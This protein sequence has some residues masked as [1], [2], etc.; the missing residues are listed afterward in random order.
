MNRPTLL[1]NLVVLWAALSLTTWGCGDDIQIPDATVRD[2]GDTGRDV[3]APDTP[4]D[5]TVDIPADWP[6]DVPYDLADMEEPV[7]LAPRVENAFSRDGSDIV[8][9]FSEAMDPTTT[10]VAANYRVEGSDATSI[11]VLSVTLEERFAFLTLDLTSTTINPDLT[12]E[13]IVSNAQDLTGNVI[14]SRYNRVTVHRSL[15][16]AIVWHQHQPL[17]LD[18]NRDEMIGPWVRKHATKDYWD[19]TAILDGYEDIHLTVNLT[20]VL[21]IQ[22]A[23]YVERLAPYVDP[24]NNTVDEEAYF[25]EMAGHTDPFVDLT[26]RDTPTRATATEEEL[27]LFYAGPWA[28]VSTSDAIMQRFPEYVA[29]RDGDRTSYDQLE[30]AYLKVWFEVAWFDPDF[31]HGPVQLSNGWVVDLSDVVDYH[32]ENGTFTLNT[33]YT[34][35]ASSDAER[36]A[37]LEVLANRL[38]AENYKIMADVIPLHRSMIYDPIT[39]EGQIEVITTPF[40]HPILPLLYDSDLARFGQPTD[41]LPSPAFAFPD[42]AYAQVAMARRYYE[43]VF[44]QP[45]RGMWP[46]EGSVAEEIVGMLALNGIEWIAT[47]QE[48]LNRSTSGSQPHYYPFK[49]DGDTAT[50]NAGSDDDA[51]VIV[52]RDS[53]LS[54]AI[55]FAYQTWRGE[56]AAADFLRNLLTMAPRFGQPDRLL[57]VV[58]D[59]ENA[60]ELYRYEH[61]GKG[62]HHALYRMLLESQEVGELVT[63]TPAEYLHG[64][65]DRSVAS[66]PIADQRELEPLWRGSWIGATFATWIG[67]S[68]ENLGWNYLLQART[69]LDLAPWRDAGGVTNHGVPRPNPLEGPPEP[70]GTPS[71]TVPSYEEQLAAYLAWQEIYAAEGSDWFWWYGEDQT[72][73]SNDDTP[74]DRGFRSHLTGMY[75]YIREWQTERFYRIF[76]DC[77]GWDANGDGTFAVAE[78]PAGCTEDPPDLLVPPDFAPIIQPRADYLRGPFET[79]PVCNGIFQPNETEWSSVAG[80]FYD[81][82]SSGTAA[83]RNDD[84][85]LIYYGYDRI[86][87]SPAEEAV[88]LAI[89]F[90]EDIAAKR[91]S[92]YRVSIYTN[93]KHILDPTMGTYQPDPQVLNSTSPED[94]PLLFV[95]G[96]AG[97]QIE[98][99]FS[100]ASQIAWSLGRANGSG[101]WTP[102]SSGG[103]CGAGNQG[104]I[105]ISNP[106]TG[107]RILEMRIPW[108][109]LDMAF[110]D[111]F[112]FLVIASEGDQPIDQAPQLESKVVFDDITNLCTVIFECDVSGSQIPINTYT[113]ITTPPPPSG[114]GIVFITGNQDQWGQWYP[115]AITLRDDGVSPD[116]VA[117]DRIWTRSFSFR[118]GLLLH[119]KYTIGTPSDEGRWAGTEEYPLTERGYTLPNT[120]STVILHEIFADRPQPSG[121]LAPNT[122]VEIVE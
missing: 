94:I 106:P 100:N 89:V 22:N 77:D 93:Y 91:G 108:S 35:A 90:N 48:V 70:G 69:D 57:T 92:N 50:G 87:E 84:I 104:P 41:L 68:E 14:D 24:I 110:G 53:Q 55:G 114:S 117:N 119:W 39:Y 36:V 17:Y 27:D 73:A 72:S 4:T 71:P 13:V 18:P 51:L 44:E 47:D 88:Y 21:L 9:R 42:D 113:N 1:F 86:P 62:F 59:G 98:I 12:Y 5:S 29:L 64:N 54:D 7:D 26:L 56:D 28:T 99:D 58:L 75:R 122:D 83:S 85:S 112:E 6:A 61:D 20:S 109:A 102:V 97:Y 10:T 67:E 38:I 8:V 25:S 80:S 76:S 34:S 121:S 79:A 101:G 65:L 105:C 63:V 60:W 11:P 95:G 40:F 116:R 66:H 46:G 37:R 3:P 111:P 82:D 15:Y 107:G 103:P 32:S 33:D 43:E 31:L 52:F 23:F 115:N 78:R 30:L 81:N 96:G 49:I 19:M 45:L 16:L 2:A 74:F 120:P 118:P